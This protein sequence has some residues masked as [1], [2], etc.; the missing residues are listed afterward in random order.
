[1]KPSADRAPR[2]MISTTTMATTTAMTMTAIEIVDTTHTENL[3]TVETNPLQRTGS[4]PVGAAG[5]IL[6]LNLVGAAGRTRLGARGLHAVGVEQSIDRRVTH[7]GLHVLAGL[8][9]RD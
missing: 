7:N 6:E 2:R 4:T 5:F 3:R 1:M 8:A 9:E